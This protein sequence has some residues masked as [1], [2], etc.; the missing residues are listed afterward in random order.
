MNRA[1]K[2]LNANEATK[3]LNKL[4]TVDSKMGKIDLGNKVVLYKINDSRFSKANL[5]E[6]ASVK[7]SIYALID[8]EIMNNL[9]K[10]L[11]KT[12]EVKSSLNT[13]N[14]E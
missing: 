4:F 10:K 5:K 6:I 7:E 8:G 11:E 12:Y 13:K 1:P 14:K 3:F 2:S 9:V